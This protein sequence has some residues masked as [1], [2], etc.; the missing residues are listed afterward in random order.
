MDYMFSMCIEN[1][2]FCVNG[3]LRKASFPLILCSSV[4]FVCAAV[5]SYCQ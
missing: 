1:E 5:D 3:K 4:D 2:Q